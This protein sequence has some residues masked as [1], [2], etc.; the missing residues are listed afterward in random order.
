ME[1]LNEFERVFDCNSIAIQ[2][3][4]HWRSTLI[5]SSGTVI[6]ERSFDNLVTTIGKQFLASFLVSAAAAAST[7]T[8]NYVA[9]GSSNTPET[10]ADTV[11]GAELVRQVGTTTY[12]SPSTV[13]IISTFS[14]GIGTGNVFEYGVFNTSVTNT[15]A[16]LNH[17]TKGLITK[18]AGDTLI[19]A[20]QLTLS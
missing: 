16:M 17:S 20:C 5:N 18:A 13:Q 9:I 15:G 11:L 12:V 3:H 4:G 2:V 6:Q 1:K 19:V 14:A 10:I 7:F 8:M